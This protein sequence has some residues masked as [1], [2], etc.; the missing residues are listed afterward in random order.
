M[1]PRISDIEILD[2]QQLAD[3]REYLGGISTGITSGVLGLMGFMTACAVGLLAGNPGATILLRALGAMAVCALVGRVL[4]LAG[5]VCV[6]EYV[7]RYKSERPRPQKPR[8]LVDLDRARRE[9]Q[10]VMRSMKKAA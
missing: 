4:G 2:D 3:P 10:D 9:H 6:R 8:Q 1:N 5:E 7:T